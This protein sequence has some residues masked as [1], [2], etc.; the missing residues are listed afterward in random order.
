MK[1]LF[2]SLCV[3]NNWILYAKAKTENYLDNFVDSYNS[4]FLFHTFQELYF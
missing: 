4:I 3:Q 2:T 1:K